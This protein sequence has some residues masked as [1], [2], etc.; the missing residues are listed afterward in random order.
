MRFEMGIL[1][2]AHFCFVPFFTGNLSLRHY[3]HRTLSRLLVAGY[4]NGC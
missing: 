2:G 3:G 1:R 4:C